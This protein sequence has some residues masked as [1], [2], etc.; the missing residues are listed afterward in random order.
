MSEEPKEQTVADRF[1][2][3]AERIDHNAAS[4]F[5]GAYVIIPPKGAFTPWEVLVLDT[6]EDPAQFLMLLQA[7]I[8][9]MMDELRAKEAQ[10]GGF[11]RRA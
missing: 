2:Q 9:A 8:S 1:R 3:M 11:G 5:G 4:S 10:Q 7:K 6:Q